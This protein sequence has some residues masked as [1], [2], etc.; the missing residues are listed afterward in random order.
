MKRMTSEICAWVL[1]SFGGMLPAFGQGHS[2]AGYELM[3][4]RQLWFRSLNAAG[5]V[6][7]Q[8]TFN[9]SN[10]A[11]S[12]DAQSGRYKRPQTGA[13]VGDVNVYTEG[14]V[15]LPLALVWGEFLFTHQNVSDALY[16][17]S[18][19]DPY[20]GQ[21]YYVVDKHSSNWRNQKYHM[22][23]RASTPI[24]WRRWAFGVEGLYNA[25]LAAKQRDI[26]VDTR[27]Y[28][29]QVIPSVVFAISDNNHL[30]F[31]L[32]YM[33]MK[34]DSQQQNVN[35]YSEQSFYEL[36]GLG[37][38]TIGLGDGRTTNYFGNK[39]GAGLQYGYHTDHWSILSELQYSKHVENVEI[40]YSTPRKEGLMKDDNFKFTFNL[41]RGGDRF[42]HVAG[43]VADYSDISGVQY[44]SQRDNT[45]SQSG[46]IS[47]HKYVRSI[48]RRGTYDLS[49]SLIRGRQNEYDWRIDTGA[50]YV[51]HDDAFILPRSTKD[52]RNLYLT[53]GAKK[54]FILGDT[55]QQRL[56]LAVNGTLKN[57]ISGAYVYGGPET[58]Y[59]TVT[60][61]EPQDEAYLVSDAWGAGV[62]ATYSQQLREDKNLNVYACVGYT[63][64]RSNAK[65]MGH[66]SG[67]NLSL[68]F[69]F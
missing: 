66:R 63:Y 60:D 20:R 65:E 2:A 7:D 5:A 17:S 12:Y 26:R 32:I 23:F 67:L 16:N 59:I 40:S 13:K 3:K 36:Y 1:L 69:N 31:S 48:Y 18:I 51:T 45:E 62:S 56:L 57:G 35:H 58:K 27:F 50:S 22:C 39:W 55:R 10:V 61:L 29:L 33:S 43:F 21:P 9:Y 47:L 46:W 4:E 11:L 15:R 6:I 44:F 53:L 34:E 30:G 8:P 38:A 41:I 54:N 68:G 25:S 37:F 42:T 52:S 49:Y 24:V 28:R 19:T 14:A 64:L